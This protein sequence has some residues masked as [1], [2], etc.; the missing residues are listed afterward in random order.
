MRV[1]PLGTSSGKPTLKRSVSALA[2][3]REAE[4]LL[5][6]C[7]EGAQVQITR[8]G[9]SPSRLSAV[10]ITH[11][12]G[13]H[14]NGVPGLL[15]TM[16]LDRRT[17][18]LTLVGPRGVREYLDTLERLRVIFLPYPIELAEFSS[19]PDLRMVYETADYT[20]S[21][22]PLDHRLFALGYRI[23]ERARPG[24]F[25]V[26]RARALGVPEGPLWG[27]L[28]SGE[29][30]RL[31][32]GKVVHSEDVLGAPRS[33]KSVAYCLDTRPCDSSLELARGVDLLI[34][35]A[36]YTEEFAVEAQQY[37]HSTAAQAASTARDAGA[38]RLLITHFSTRY[39]DAAQLLDEARAIFPDTVLAEDL[40]EIEI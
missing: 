24:R 16:G 36:T 27:R 38:R 11:L 14:F 26:E 22:R 2:V 29:D 33:G 21:A 18:E 35:E 25:N 7:G 6:D 4:W 34:H 13:D 32:D 23:D 30:V 19:F 15:S 1:V 28:Q 12:H 3:V 9:L 37:G 20:V 31:D 40:T 39:P 10:F 8:A 5:F 17:R